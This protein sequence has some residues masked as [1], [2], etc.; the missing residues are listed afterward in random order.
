[1]IAGMADRRHAAD[2]DIAWRVFVGTSK[3]GDFYQPSGVLSGFDGSSAVHLLFTGAKQS[4][5]SE[6]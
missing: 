1:V 3:H 6:P 2:R 5:S 4:D